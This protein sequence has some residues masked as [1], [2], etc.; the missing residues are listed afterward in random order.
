MKQNK[1]LSLP[2]VLLLVLLICLLGACGPYQDTGKQIPSAPIKAI[3]MLD[4]SKGWALTDQNI[5]FTSN[6]GQNW[7][8]VTPSGSAYSKYGYGDFLNDK[9][10]WVVSTGQP[11]DKSVNVLRTSDG[12]QHWD[13]ST[14]SVNDVS[15]LDYPHF[16][17]PQEGFLELAAFGGAGA[18]SQAVGIFHTT[19]GGQNWTEISDTEHAGGLPHGG[20][21][22]GI[23]FKDA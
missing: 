9:Y 22:T 13:S 11:I 23:A 16:L 1:L 7:K 8:D 3:R 20:I 14:I 6:G 2:G 5:L 4:H 17:T 18:G 10:A 15:V 19:D 21:K 12:G